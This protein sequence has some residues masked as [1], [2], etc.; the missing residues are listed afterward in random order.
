MI[1]KGRLWVSIKV[2]VILTRVRHQSPLNTEWNLTLTTISLSSILKT[3]NSSSQ[4]QNTNAATPSTTKTQ[5]I[6]TTI[7]GKTTILT[8]TLV[9][10]YKVLST[11]LTTKIIGNIS[12]TIMVCR[13]FLRS[14]YHHTSRKWTKIFTKDLTKVG[15][16]QLWNKF[17]I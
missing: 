4:S 6:S 10:D 17:R 14:N 5:K 11:T 13:K 1:N 2:R 8:I 9:K 7:A 15:K 12:T 3:P 16:I